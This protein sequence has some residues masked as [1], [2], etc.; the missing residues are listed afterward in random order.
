MVITESFELQDSDGGDGDGEVVVTL[1]LTFGPLTCVLVAHFVTFSIP[2]TFI[3][4]HP[5]RLCVEASLQKFWAFTMVRA[6]AG[7]SPEY[8][9]KP[10]W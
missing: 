5:E 9:V 8:F 6:T 10:S 1:T 3:L 4:P 2:F 7:Q